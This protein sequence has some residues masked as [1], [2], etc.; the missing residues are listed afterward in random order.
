M[1]IYTLIQH[2]PA[3][4]ACDAT[5]FDT[6]HEA[7]RYADVHRLHQHGWRSV[8]G[9]EARENSHYSKRWGFDD[10]HREAWYLMDGERRLYQPLVSHLDQS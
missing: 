3:E 9:A 6:E 4:H 2:S 5:V 8:T 7:E 10:I 1:S